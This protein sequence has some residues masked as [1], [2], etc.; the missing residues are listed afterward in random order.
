[1]APETPERS[2]PSW[3]I[4]E[5]SENAEEAIKALQVYKK[6][7]A[8]KSKLALF[9]FNMHCKLKETS[10][11]RTIQGSWKCPHYEGEFLQDHSIE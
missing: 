5:T 1:M 3:A 8:E 4:Q 2:I 11:H 6:K 10:S 9:L 7:D